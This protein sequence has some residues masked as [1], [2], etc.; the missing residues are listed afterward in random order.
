M[1]DYVWAPTRKFAEQTNVWRFM[2]KLGFDEREVFLMWSREEPELFWDAMLK[3]CGVEWYQP[4]RSV[5][6][7]DRGPEWAEWF[8]GGR[9]NIVHNCLDRHVKDTRPAIL[10][11]A[12]NGE[13]RAVSFAELARD[14]GRLANALRQMG[15]DKGDRIA[16]VMPM[17][18]EVVTV[19]YAALKIGLVVV[20]VFAGFGPG[21]IHDRL[22]DSGARAV[23]TAD[24]LERRGKRLPLKAKVDEALAGTDVGRVVVMR[25]RGGDV[26][27]TGR[28]RWWHDV[29]QGPE[30]CETEQMESEDRALILYT[31]GST[32]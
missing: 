6:R 12:E 20:P 16:M 27:W 29:V 1:S 30:Q 17:T 15:L 25:Y 4:Y 5:V 10:W 9:I 24:G 23:F 18:P 26:P 32:G 14:V 19:L 13:R 22:A 3:E 8:P 21:A 28:D 31:S 11:E 2:Q 7:L